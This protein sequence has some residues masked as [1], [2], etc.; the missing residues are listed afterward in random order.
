VDYSR[1]I[2]ALVPGVQGRVL[3]VLARTETDL[4]MRGVAELA[5]VSPQQASVVLGRLVELGVAERRDVP[6]VALV[7]L[8]RDN[9]AA[10]AVQRLAHLRQDA[11]EQLRALATKIE[12]S[13]ASL[14]VFGSFARGEAGVHSDVDVL[15]VRPAPL[16][17][18]AHD[19]WTDSLG[20]WVDLATR[21]LGNAVNL[22]EASVEEIPG[23]LS[24]EAPSM[25]ANIAS[26]GIV[27]AGSTLPGLLAAA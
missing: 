17:D 3:A 27:L 13:P 11:I 15:A 21:V 18:D 9:L 22:V 23:L 14:V 19:A 5:G 25:W 24:R 7:R 16:S 4:T 10:Q 2:E 26:E 8:A 20:R 6:P 12:P 1:P